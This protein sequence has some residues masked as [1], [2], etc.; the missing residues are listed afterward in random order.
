MIEYLYLFLGHLAGDTLFSWRL[1]DAKRRNLFFLGVH[2]AI[3]AIVVAFF[4][5]AFMN[6]DFAI[7]KAIILFVSHFI[8]DYWKCYIAKI[9]GSINTRNLRY[10]FIDQ[11]L[12][13]IVLIT[14]T[15]P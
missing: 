14:I 10:T 8:I 4:L 5:Y 1:K 3:Y 12:H 2:S 6:S 9:D 15:V 7:W 13:L 11:V